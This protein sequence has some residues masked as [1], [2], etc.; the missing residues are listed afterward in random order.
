[1][2]ILV[3]N[4]IAPFYGGLNFF[5][6]C[7]RSAFYIFMATIFFFSTSGFF[8]ITSQT[9]LHYDSDYGPRVDNSS[10]VSTISTMD[11]AHSTPKR[12][13]AVYNFS[14][15]TT[16]SSRL[17]PQFISAIEKN[18]LKTEL[19]GSMPRKMAKR[20]GLYIDDILHFSEVYRLDPVWVL[21][22]IWTE[23]HFRPG[24]KSYV[25]ATGLMQIMPR[26]GRF[27]NE[28]LNRPSDK[29]LVSELLVDPR[30]NIEL[31]TFYLK[32]LLKRFK[33]HRY[34]TVAYNM[35]PRFVSRRIRSG[36]PIGVRNIY[37]D[38]V[39]RHYSLL[40][41]AIKRLDAQSRS[42]A[43][44]SLILRKTVA[45]DTEYYLGQ[46]IIVKLMSHYAARM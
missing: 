37:W 31:G 12:A 20:A 43:K 35:G 5:L 30:T 36:G 16:F 8:E 19:L 25:S 9:H 14:N 26:T 32:R 45:F 44:D 1:M 2:K 24:A 34:A 3:H 41:R 33:S 29:K 42:H 17:R 18:L 39:K 46:D 6:V 7:R 22:V 4:I 15:I 21:S 13:Y 27:L 28:L 10:F 38:K 40:F 23:S 11:N